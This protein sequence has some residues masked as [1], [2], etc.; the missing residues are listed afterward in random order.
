MSSSSYDYIIVGAG[1]AGC[2][3]ANRLSADPKVSV[4]LIEAGGSDKSLWVKIPAG[5]FGLLAGPVFDS[6]FFWLSLNYSSANK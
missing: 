5:I 1:S 6:D 4:C 3:V 2:V